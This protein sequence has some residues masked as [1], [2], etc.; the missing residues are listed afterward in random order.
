MGRKSTVSGRSG[1]DGAAAR[2]NELCVMPMP[3]ASTISSRTDLE[4]L[5]EGWDFEAKKAAGRD[6]QGKLPDDFWPTS[7]QTT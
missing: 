5:R 1:Y 4:L 2:L 3:A 6:G 7:N